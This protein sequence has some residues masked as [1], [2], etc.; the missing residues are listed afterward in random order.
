MRFDTDVLGRTSALH[1][2]GNVHDVRVY[3]TDSRPKSRVVTDVNAAAFLTESQSRDA[4]GRVAS[5]V[6]VGGN[7]SF[8]YT[9][10]GAVSGSGETSGGTLREEHY[11]GE[12][13]GNR[14]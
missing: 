10:M 13:E 7:V 4:A 11:D 3:D 14:T 6:Y 12:G 2:P 8:T 1:Y 9:G 5:A